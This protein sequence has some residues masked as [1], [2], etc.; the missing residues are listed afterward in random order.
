M[1]NAAH[2]VPQRHRGEQPYAKAPF[3]FLIAALLLALPIPAAAQQSC[4]PHD[5]VVEHLHKTFGERAIWSGLAAPGA[6]YE[7][8]ASPH[9]SWTIVQLQPNGTACVMAI[10]EAS[11]I[12]SLMITIIPGGENI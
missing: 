8:F 12:L 4:A 10:G 3:L 11:E 1:R 7:L 6:L 5:I 9:G 2:S